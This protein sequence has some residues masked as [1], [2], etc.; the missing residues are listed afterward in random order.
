MRFIFRLHLVHHA[1]DL[2]KFY[3][4][5]LGSSC[6]ITAGDRFTIQT[7]FQKQ[8]DQLD[9]H[10]QLHVSTAGAGPV[11]GETEESSVGPA[12]DHT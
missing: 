10:V 2:Q 1:N 9:L 4:L 3:I 6:H 11:F 8:L 7:H 12:I 5:C